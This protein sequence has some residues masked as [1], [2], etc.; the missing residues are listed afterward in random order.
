[1]LVIQLAGVVRS[2]ILG[3]KEFACFS[4][5]FPKCF[6]LGYTDDMYLC[7][8]DDPEMSG[9]SSELNLIGFLIIRG[10]GRKTLLRD[11]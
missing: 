3:G 7:L 6:D 11:V 9:E 5:T 2:S 4:K 8:P 1:M 10:A